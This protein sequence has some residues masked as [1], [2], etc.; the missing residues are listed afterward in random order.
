MASSPSPAVLGTFKRFPSGQTP[1][2]ASKC[3]RGFR[4]FSGLRTW[5]LQKPCFR[6]IPQRGAFR[7]PTRQP[8][9]AKHEEFKGLWR[10]KRR[11]DLPDLGHFA[12]SWKTLPGSRGVERFFEKF[13]EESFEQCFPI[14]DLP[15]LL[16]VRA[17]RVADG[18]RR[19]ARCA[20]HA[21]CR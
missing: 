18:L 1:V 13:L 2:L 3:F 21:R 8:I 5:T 19:F 6:C 7:H 4:I 10:S 9:P 14:K 17:T 20:R 11:F 15:A 12:R 16:G